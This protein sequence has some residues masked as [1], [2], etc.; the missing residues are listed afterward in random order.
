LTVV[1]DTT[2]AP[3]YV[4]S[5]RERARRAGVAD[6]IR[7]T[8]RLAEEAV[9][10][11]LRR[12]HVLAVPSRYEPFGMAHLEAMGFGCVPIATTN[13]GPSEF[14]DDGESGFV[15]EPDDPGAIADRLAGV[16][17]DRDRLAALGVAARAAFERQPG[18]TERMDR[19]VDFLEARCPT[20]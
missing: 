19:A 12:A 14:I 9:A 16:I 5:A 20:T 8:G 1:G 13:G 15:V 7:F 10:D 17:D 11:R 3:E 6:R 2:V 4:A 18:W